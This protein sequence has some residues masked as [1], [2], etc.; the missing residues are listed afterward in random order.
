MAAIFWPGTRPP[1]E[2]DSDAAALPY[3]DLF[4]RSP[5]ALMLTDIDGTV[6]DANEAAAALHGLKRDE[7]IGH[8]T[9]GSIQDWQAT[10]TETAQKE[11][12][13]AG[14][15][16]REFTLQPHVG[17]PIRVEA[18]GTLVSPI[19]RGHVLIRLRDLTRAHASEQMLRDLEPDGFPG[20]GRYRGAVSGPALG[21]AHIRRGN[22]P[23]G[24]GHR[25]RSR[26]DGCRNHR[27]PGLRR[28]LGRGWPR[29]V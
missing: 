12:V 18:I 17:S 29:H 3:R 4:R 24:A 20:N 23:K 28:V 21:R 14:T 9:L 10:D 26:E 8:S 16:V 25:C 7:L 15:I 1:D 6:L 5:E 11:A 19:E 13:A 2:G 27:S 22:S